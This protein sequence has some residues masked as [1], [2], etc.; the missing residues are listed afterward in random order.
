MLP[1]TYTETQEE[2]AKRQAKFVA[3][4]NLEKDLPPELFRQVLDQVSLHSLISKW[5]LDR[6]KK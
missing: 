1:S 5:L 2:A 4:R 3:L 6:S